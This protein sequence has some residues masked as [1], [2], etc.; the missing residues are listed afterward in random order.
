M[1]PHPGPPTQLQPDM[2]SSH[3]PAPMPAGRQKHAS[4]VGCRFLEL[5]IAC[6]MRS[7]K[8]WWSPTNASGQR[9]RVLRMRFRHF[10]TVRTLGARGGPND[11]IIPIRWLPRSIYSPRTSRITMSS[12]A[13][14]PLSI[15]RPIS[16]TPCE[17]SVAEHLS[18]RRKQRF[19]GPT[20]EHRRLSEERPVAHD[21]AV[22]GPR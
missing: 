18:E 12:K 16:P 2:S 13:V 8:Q 10:L 9:T 20:I 6:L 14:A 22:M 3:A 5:Q 17:V 21:G 15:Q 1:T 7:S 4:C 19:S 11:P